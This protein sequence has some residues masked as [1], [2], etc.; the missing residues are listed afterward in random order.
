[1]EV[2][3]SLDEVL[4]RRA[5][6]AAVR[7]SDRGAERQRSAAKDDDSKHHKQN[8]AADGAHASVDLGQVVDVQ[9]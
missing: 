8:D 1:M 3:A 7:I 9:A 2:S 4:A 5:L 6:E